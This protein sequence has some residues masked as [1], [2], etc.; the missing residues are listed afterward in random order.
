MS[1]MELSSLFSYYIY[2]NIP[3]SLLLR[4][5]GNAIFFADNS[6]AMVQWGPSIFL[7]GEF[8]KANCEQYLALLN[9]PGS[10]KYLYYPNDAWRTLIQDTYGDKLKDIYLRVYRSDDAATPECD[11]IP[12]CIVP[13]TREFLAKNLPGTELITDELY[14]YTDM[15][16]FY[17]NGYGLALVKDDKVCGFCLSEYSVDNSHGI[18]I[19]IDEPYRRQGYA[20]K[21]TNAFLTHCKEKNETAYWVCDNYNIPS[22]KTAVSTG[23]VL[24]STMHYFEL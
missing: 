6:G 18:N 14:S 20:R 21:M 15:E 17:Q 3:K 24:K 9:N 23:F 1:T 7:D 13:V 19:W 4:K 12:E 2:R 22:N 5:K 8:T 11:E 10:P 16:D